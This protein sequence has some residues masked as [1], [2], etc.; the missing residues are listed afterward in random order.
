MR[1]A[2]EVKISLI[3]HEDAG[4]G[5]FVEHLRH[6]LERAGHHLVQV[7]ERDADL[8]SALA[9]PTELIVAAG[10]DGTV[11]RAARALAGRG[12]PLAIL[13]LGTANN[14]ARSLGIGGSL[15]E[16]VDSWKDAPRHPLDLGVACGEWGETRFVEAIGSG[17]ITAGIAAM[18]R[19]PAP[20][21]DEDADAKLA[22]AVRTYRD[23]LSRLAPRRWRFTADGEEVDG[24]FVLLEVLNI[25]SVGPNLVLSPDGDPS[26]GHLDVVTAGE[27]ERAEIDDY[28]GQRIAGRDAR[29]S[30]PTRRARRVEICGWEDMHLDD[31]VSS[32]SRAGASSIR[33]G[34]E[35]AAVQLLACA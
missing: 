16:L 4:D 17:L 13:P 8:E 28:L 18:E 11:W 20:H 25:N 34:I 30:L 12:R 31:Q 29:L 19:E 27:A 14:I 23:V 5:V 26:D 10:G 21:A 2:F 6:L 3:Y 22:R 32:R 33:I 24:E 15:A 9:G 35:P 1:T 7:V